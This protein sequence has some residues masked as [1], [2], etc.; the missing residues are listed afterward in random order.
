MS[1]YPISELFSPSKS[2]WH[3][4]R[5]KAQPI[6]DAFH[7]R[8]KCTSGQ[9]GIDVV[10]NVNRESSSGAS[11]SSKLGQLLPHVKLEFDLGTGTAAAFVEELGHRR[12]RG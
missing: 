3:D 4:V 9:A 5:T 1:Q 10:G 11:C 7:G 12:L 2:A 8:G 6:C